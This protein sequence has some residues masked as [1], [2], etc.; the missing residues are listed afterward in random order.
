MAA[1]LLAVAADIIGTHKIII[2]KRKKGLDRSE[3][4]VKAENEKEEER[5]T[6]VGE[7][8]EEEEE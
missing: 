1:F 4:V 2:V 5:E 3:V 8:G 7:Q 6:G